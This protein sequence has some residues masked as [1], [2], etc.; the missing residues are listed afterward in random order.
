VFGYIPALEIFSNWCHWNC[1]G[2]IEIITNQ[3]RWFRK[4]TTN[5]LGLIR[6]V[7]MYIKSIQTMFYFNVPKIQKNI[8]EL[9]KHSK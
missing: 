9:V 4:Y 5:Y 2:E 7:N 6:M 8:N 1:V 3:H